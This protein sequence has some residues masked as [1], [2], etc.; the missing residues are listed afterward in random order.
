MKS[1]CKKR[2]PGV[3]LPALI[4]NIEKMKNLTKNIFIQPKLFNN[5]CVRF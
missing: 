5:L 1:V 3:Y 4:Y 2:Q